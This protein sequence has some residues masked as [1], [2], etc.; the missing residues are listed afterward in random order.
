M[1][2]V[3]IRTGNSAFKGPEGKYELARILREIAEKL[4]T[5][6]T[7]DHVMDVNGNKV[8]GWLIK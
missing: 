7:G 4:E 2:E 3:K 5:G 8:G 1:F 6:K